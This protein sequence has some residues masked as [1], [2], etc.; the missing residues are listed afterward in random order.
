MA[1]WQPSSDLAKAVYLAGF[2]YDPTQDILYSRM[3]AIQRQLGYAYGY[4]AFAFLISANIDCEPIFFEYNKK[5]WMIELWKGQ[6]GLETGCEIGIYNRNPNDHS[7]IYNTLDKY[8]GKRPDDTNPNHNLFYN[9]VD[10][11][12]MLEM[13]FSLHRKD[14]GEDTVVF[15]R[16]PEKDWWLT[17]FKWGIYSK[18]EQLKMDITITFTNE[19][20]KKVF[21]QALEKMGYTCTISSGS[22]SFIFDKPTTYQPRLHNPIMP[23]IDEANKEIATKYHALGFPNNDPNKIQGELV[24]KIEKYFKNYASYFQDVL[25]KSIKPLEDWVD[26]IKG[27]GLLRKFKLI[28][29]S[30]IVEFSNESTEYTLEKKDAGIDNSWLNMNQGTYVVQASSIVPPES[31]KRLLLED[32]FGPFGA[33]GWVTYDLVDKNGNKEEIKFSFGCPLFKNNFVKISGAKNNISYKSKSGNGNWQTN[34]TPLRG[35]PF[36]IQFII[37]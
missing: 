18:P 3:Y 27:L 36:Y 21:V 24:K 23:S 30:C 14:K 33:A 6:Y 8:L 19:E 25:S 15:T 20:M 2:D 31:V 13:N 34:D 22:V 29:C 10:N 16:G 1:Q 9:C 32:N 26:A 17:G 35:H 7:G 37:S 5:V 4:D 11:S 12:E 28:D